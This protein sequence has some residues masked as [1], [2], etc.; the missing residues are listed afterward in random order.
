MCWNLAINQNSGGQSKS[1]AWQK[2]TNVVNKMPTNAASPHSAQ[3][4]KTQ[5]QKKKK[6]PAKCERSAAAAAAMG[7]WAVGWSCALGRVASL[8]KVKQ[9]LSNKRGSQMLRGAERST[10]EWSEERGGESG[11]TVLRCWCKSLSAL[12][13]QLFLQHHQH[14]HHHHTPLLLPA[15]RNLCKCVGCSHCW[16]ARP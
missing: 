14:H 12:A 10:G 11:A 5:Q 3:K 1:F 6:K 7:G 16:L 2:S 8:W 9:N 15:F 4:K 13:A